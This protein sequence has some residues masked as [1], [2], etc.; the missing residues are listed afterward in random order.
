MGVNTVIQNV[1]WRRARWGTLV[2]VFRTKIMDIEKASL[3]NSI[4][5]ILQAD[6]RFSI[7]TI[8]ISIVRLHIFASLIFISADESQKNK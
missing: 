8:L 3:I 1:K 4:K 7:N 2:D 5:Q 6:I